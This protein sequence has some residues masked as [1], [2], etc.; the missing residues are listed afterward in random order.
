MM[1]DFGYYY[2]AYM[3]T[4]ACQQWYISMSPYGGICD[5]DG[6]IAFDV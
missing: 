3:S 6:Y 5:W 1:D 2:P 4:F